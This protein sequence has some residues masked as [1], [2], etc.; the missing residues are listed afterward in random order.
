MKKFFLNISKYLNSFT[1]VAIYFLFVQILI[2][3][4][5][6]NTNTYDIFFWF[7]NHTPILFSIAFFLKNIDI[8]KTLINIGFLIQFIWFLDLLSKI[9]LGFHILGITE[10]LFLRENLLANS[11]SVIIHLFTTS[12]A[13][14]FT[15]KNKTK[16]IVLIYSFI[17]LIFLYFSTLIFTQVENNI[18]CLYLICSLESLTFP[19]YNIFWIL[20]M[21]VIIILP[22]FYFQK[23]LYFLSQKRINKKYNKERSNKEK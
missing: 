12:I 2:I 21:F 23:L 19:F 14:L 1:L 9:F 3:Y 7:C 10:Y 15:Y 20:I 11:I 22:T 13:I 5:N 16:N 6:I 17:Y 18:N 4:G 8:I